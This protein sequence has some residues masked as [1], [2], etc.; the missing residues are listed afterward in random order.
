LASDSLFGQQIIKL[1]NESVT[2][3]QMSYD[4]LP[5]VTPQ[6]S[7]HSTQYLEGY[8]ANVY[9]S[10]D[11]II[12]ISEN[13]K[14]DIQ[15][16]L[17]Y[18]DKRVPEIE[19]IRLGDDFDYVK[20]VKPRNI[21]VKNNEFILCVGTIEARKNHTLLYYTYKEAKQRHINLPPVVIVGRLGWLS[22]DIYEIINNDPDIKDLFIF[23]HNTSDNELS[24]LYENCLFTVYPSFYEGWG[25][26]VAESIARGVPCICSNLSS[27]P[28]IA[29]D[30]LEYFS[31]YSTE[32]CLEA[33]TAMYIPANL[34]K[35]K[36]A[37][38]SY[39]LTSWDTAF[40]NVMRLIGE[41]N[42]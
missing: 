34:K 36:V 35:A 16:Y 1:K 5:L 30:K 33:I 15:K 11:L 17:K 28:E 23:Q 37:I 21:F 27:I 42:D 10:M 2:I 12:T 4:I 22:H 24:W 39:T 19:V 20:P 8:I 7:G 18:K 13:T 41:R 38:K 9:P 25:L 31:P 26:P 29:G 32:E 14:K 3:I 6:Y 40:N